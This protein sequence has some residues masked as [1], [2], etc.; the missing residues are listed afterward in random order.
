MRVFFGLIASSEQK[1]NEL[2]QDIYVYEVSLLLIK[3]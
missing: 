1:I 2:L 3:K